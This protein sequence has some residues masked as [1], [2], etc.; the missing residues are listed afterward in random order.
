MKS[1]PRYWN[2]LYDSPSEVPTL[3]KFFN[4]MGSKRNFYVVNLTTPTG[5]LR[6]MLDALT[7]DGYSISFV[8]DDDANFAISVRKGDKRVKA[9]II[10]VGV[11]YLVISD[12]SNYLI[13]NVLIRFLDLYYPDVARVYYSSTDLRKLLEN[14]QNKTDGEIIIGRTVVYSRIKGRKETRGRERQVDVKYT[15]KLLEETFEEAVEKNE[16]ID[17]IEFTLMLEGKEELIGNLSREGVFRCK[18]S[19]EIFYKTVLS[20]ASNITSKKVNFFK[21]RARIERKEPKPV[22]IQFGSN[23]FEEKNQNYKFIASIKELQF[24]STSVYHSNPYIH[25]STVDYLDGSSCDILVTSSNKA[26]VVP[27]LRSSYAS[28]ARLINH[29]FEKFGEG[30]VKEYEA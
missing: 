7:P 5:N 27:Q 19:F 23:I 18:R 17:K 10:R 16:A 8:G 3:L 12:A 14:M 2:W 21:D 30:E 28:L 29:I 1:T 15:E 9:R 25:L 4:R 11:S 22:V 6:K 26:T 13:R 24:S 20:D